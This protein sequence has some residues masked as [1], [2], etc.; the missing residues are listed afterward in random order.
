MFQ[1]HI[2]V[3]A[4]KDLQDIVDYYDLKAPSISDR[5]LKNVYAE[6]D[7]LVENPT[8][9]QKRYKDTRVRYVKGFPFGIHYV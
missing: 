5:F 1:L 8:L 3:L 9:F 4:Q 2:R 7:F 6:F